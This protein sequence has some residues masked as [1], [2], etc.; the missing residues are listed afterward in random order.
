MSCQWC[1]DT[2]ISCV[3]TQDITSCRDA[4]AYGAFTLVTSLCASPKWSVS[5]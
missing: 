1:S 2:V 3:L 4:N 5:E